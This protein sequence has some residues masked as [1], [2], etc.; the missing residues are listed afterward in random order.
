MPDISRNA[1]YAGRQ[2][3]TFR[4]AICGFRVTKAAKIPEIGNIT[5]FRDFR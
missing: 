3:V 5:D 2:T 1:P 4:N